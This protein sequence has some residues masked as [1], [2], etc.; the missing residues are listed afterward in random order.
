M[1]VDAENISTDLILAYD[2]LLNK[3]LEFENTAINISYAYNSSERFH[4]LP[5][6]VCSHK[7]FV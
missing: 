6:F 3:L 2:W 4:G 7:S 1:P 5:A